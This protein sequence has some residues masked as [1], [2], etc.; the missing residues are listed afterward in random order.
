MGI[1]DELTKLDNLS[2]TPGKDVQERARGRKITRKKTSKQATKQSNKQENKLTNLHDY[3]QSFLRQKPS[4]IATFRLSPILL[5][6]LDEVQYVA[7]KRHKIK[8]T[9]YL[10]VTV[11]LA[12]LFWDYEQKGRESHLYRWFKDN[13]E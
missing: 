5:E 3:M 8:L 4:A 6:K 9:K 11:A 1:Y 13:G 7:K 10:L 12:V 2:P